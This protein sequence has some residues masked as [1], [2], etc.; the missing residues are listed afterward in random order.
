MEEELVAAALTMKQDV[1][2]NCILQE[3]GFVDG[4]EG[5]PLF[6]DN[7]LVVHVTRNRTCSPSEKTHCAEQFLQS[8]A[9]RGRQ[10]HHPLR[11]D[12]RPTC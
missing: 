3:L 8:R 1:F 11:E 10:D 4:F 5:V 12:A 2:C 6:I 7:T 9:D